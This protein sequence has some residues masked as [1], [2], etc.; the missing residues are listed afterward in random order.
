MEI[1]TNSQAE[2]ISLGGKFARALK[3]KDVIVLEGQLGG[4][5]TTFTK[6][7]LK[8]LGCRQRV[9]SPSFTLVRQYKARKFD[10]Y[11]LDLYRLKRADV[12]GL[13]IEDFLYSEKSI[14]FIEWGSKIAQDLDKYLKIEFLFSG[15]NSRKLKFSAQGH[16]K[17]RIKNLKELLT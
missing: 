1:K 9:L 11:H 5:K 17:E 8:G 3:E 4:G 2:T 14:S 13:G 10:V 15:Q 6:G 16:D 7:V 12:L